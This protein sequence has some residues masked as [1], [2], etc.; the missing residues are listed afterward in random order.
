MQKKGYCFAHAALLPPM[1]HHYFATMPKG[2]YK[3]VRE[4]TKLGLDT[5][6]LS[7][8]WVWFDHF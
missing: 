7:E 6:N 2:S 1:Q 5:P 3:R 4:D 8:L